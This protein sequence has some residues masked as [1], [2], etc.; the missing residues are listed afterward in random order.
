[1][2]HQKLGDTRITSTSHVNLREIESYIANRVILAVGSIPL[3]TCGTPI[4]A[5]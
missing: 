1:M 2:F 3:H 4:G 5:L